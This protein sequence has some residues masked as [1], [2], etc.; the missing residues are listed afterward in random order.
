GG[1]GRGPAACAGGTTRPRRPWWSTGPGPAGARPLGSAAAPAVPVREPGVPCRLLA[2]EPHLGAPRVVA[3]RV[4]GVEEHRAHVALDLP[5][6][7]PGP[8]VERIGGP[9]S[10]DRLREDRCLPP[11]VVVDLALRCGTRPRRIG[12]TL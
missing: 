7:R 1:S 12:G 2:L 3:G 10:V 4:R 6:G 8:V 5:A 9:G 11:G